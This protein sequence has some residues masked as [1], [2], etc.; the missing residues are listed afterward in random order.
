MRKYEPVRWRRDQDLVS[1]RNT[2]ASK[3]RINDF[4]RAN[5]HKEVLCFQR[6]I[7]MMMRV[8]KVTEQLLQFILV[9]KAKHQ[10]CS[11]EIIV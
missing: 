8:P 1:P 6:S 2:K 10:G 5:P 3:E 4:I 7:C 9:T 11:I